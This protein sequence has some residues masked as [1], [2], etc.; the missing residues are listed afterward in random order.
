MGLEV[1]SASDEQFAVLKS[2]V[3]PVR[4]KNHPVRLD[5]ETID[6]LYHRI[7]KPL[8]PLL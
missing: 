5:V 2:S 7:L 3:N 1:P 8:N 6:S 4:L